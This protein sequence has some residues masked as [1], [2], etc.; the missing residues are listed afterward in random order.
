MHEIIGIIATLFVLVSFLF[1]NEKRIRQV[2]IIGAVMFV[3]YGIIIGAIS[4]YVLNGA[5]IIIHIIKLLNQRR[6]DLNESNRKD[7]S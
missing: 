7:I 5:L 4:V 3:V 1:T 2:N 6:R